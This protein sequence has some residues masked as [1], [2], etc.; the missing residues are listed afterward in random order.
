[1]TRQIGQLART[2]SKKGA[3]TLE[4]PSVRLY[5]Q[6]PASAAC[7]VSNED[8]LANKQAVRKIS[9]NIE[10]VAQVGCTQLLGGFWTIRK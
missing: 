4:K 9:L 5:A 3:K 1:L 2:R 8:S 10:R 7:A 6:R